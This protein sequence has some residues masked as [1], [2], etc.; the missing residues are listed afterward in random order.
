[1]YC[2]ILLR[3]Q[4]RGN[5]EKIISEMEKDADSSTL[6][7][8]DGTINTDYFYTAPM[9]RVKKSNYINVY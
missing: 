6:D 1:M 7:S 4:S 8:P 2:S 5:K 9:A 3:C